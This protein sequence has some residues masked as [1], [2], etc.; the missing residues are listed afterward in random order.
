[1]DRFS[2]GLS[3]E[4]YYTP[5]MAFK[6]IACMMFVFGCANMLLTGT[7]SGVKEAGF[8]LDVVSPIR[9]I[10]PKHPSRT[11]GFVGDDSTKDEGPTK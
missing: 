7:I 10:V 5:K 11:S 4:A 9:T 6:Q 2:T 1:M 8:E 3:T